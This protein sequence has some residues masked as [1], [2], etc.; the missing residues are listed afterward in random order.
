MPIPIW[1]LRKREP[2]SS[3]W[4]E[5]ANRRQK[6]RK[7]HHVGIPIAISHVAFEVDDLE[8][9]IQNKEV[10]I[11]PNSPAKGITVAFIVDNG[12][13]IDLI[14]EAAEPGIQMSLSFFRKNAE[15]GPTEERED[16]KRRLRLPWPRC[17]FPGGGPPRARTGCR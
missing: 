1:P 17:C 12:A 6:M 4:I 13:P 9:E 2:K 10:L 15:R 8:T 11:P 3:S 16:R 5:N 7:Y 14:D